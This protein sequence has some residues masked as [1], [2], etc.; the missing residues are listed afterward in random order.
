MID[1]EQNVTVDRG[2]RLRSDGIIEHC[3]R[4]KRAEGKGE[5]TPSY[6]DRV[7]CFSL[8]SLHEGSLHCSKYSSCEQSIL[9]DHR[10]VGAEMELCARL[11]ASMARR[12]S[13][14]R[15][16]GV[17]CSWCPLMPTGVRAPVS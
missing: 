11:S 8:P 5:R 13:R 15:A 9:S 3:R 14:S 4:R 2:Q 10:P 1:L 7:L 12:Q 6:T 16:R 17:V